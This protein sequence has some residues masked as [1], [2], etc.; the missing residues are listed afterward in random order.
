MR[1]RRLCIILVHQVIE[2]TNQKKFFLK[3][4][5][6][7]TCQKSGK[8]GMYTS[9]WKEF[10]KYLLLMQLQTCYITNKMRK[11]HTFNNQ[12]IH[13]NVVTVTSSQVTSLRNSE[14]IV[15]Q[16]FL[17]NFLGKLVLKKKKEGKKKVSLFTF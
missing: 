13:V 8:S 1:D 4:H 11:S 10:I 9:T 6:L 2:T 3:K 17:R 16:Y 15:S 12:F 14:L 7:P 5:D